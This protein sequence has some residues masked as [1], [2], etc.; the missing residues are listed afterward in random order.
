MGRPGYPLSLSK[1][2]MKAVSPRKLVGQPA[3][4]GLRT[5]KA[6][7]ITKF[8]DLSSFRKGDVLICDAIQPM[9]THIV[10]LASA[11]V[12]RRGG[13]LIQGAIIARE[14]AIPCVNGIH[15]VANFIGDGDIVPLMGI[16]VSLLLESWSSTLNSRNTN[17]R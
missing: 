12:E 4:P 11:V 14:L 13:M 8:N 9:M 10:L 15:N 16:L 5:G 1:K 2:E 7:V 17:E 6:E 3:A